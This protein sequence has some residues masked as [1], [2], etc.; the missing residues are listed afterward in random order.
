MSR[1]ERFMSQ[2]NYSF[3]SGGMDTWFNNEELSV[4]LHFLKEMEDQSLPAG[5]AAMAR[6]LLS[7]PSGSTLYKRLL[8]TWPKVN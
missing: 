7:F 8:D 2:V 5:Q 6:R 1:K 4:F 3:G